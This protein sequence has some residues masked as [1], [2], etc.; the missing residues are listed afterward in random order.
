MLTDLLD[1]LHVLADL[2]DVGEAV[3]YLRVAEA[4]VED[5]VQ[6]EALVLGDGDVVDFVSV[7]GL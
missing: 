1:V 5:G 3:H 7:D 6:G 4:P 2:L